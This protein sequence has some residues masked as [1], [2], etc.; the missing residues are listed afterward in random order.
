MHG[1]VA[2]RANR[3][4]KDIKESTKKKKRQSK[5]VIRN[6]VGFEIYEN[7]FLSGISEKSC[8]TDSEQSCNW[9]VREE[10]SRTF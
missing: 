9:H 2:G 4:L 1:I 7:L 3:I 10:L 6:E 8:T 5:G